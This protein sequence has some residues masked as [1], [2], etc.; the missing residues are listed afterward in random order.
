MADQCS[1]L[2]VLGGVQA[3]LEPIM[4]FPVRLST[5]RQV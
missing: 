2:D 5:F 1:E 3:E 4:D